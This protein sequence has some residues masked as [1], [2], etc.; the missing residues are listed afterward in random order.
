MRVIL[1]RHGETELNARGAYRGRLDVGLSRRGRAES[2]AAG[3]ALRAAPLAAVYA[4][5]LRRA[6]QTAG[7]IAARHRALAVEAAPEFIDMDFGE[8]QGK[9]VAEVEGLWPEVF[10]A[11]VERPAEARIPGGETLAAVRDRAL[12]GLRRLAAAHGDAAVVLVSHGVVNKVTLCAVLGLPVAGFWSVKQDTGA[13]SIFEFSERGSKLFLMNDV[14]HR[15]SLG[16]VVTEMG[17]SRTPVG[18]STDDERGH[19]QWPS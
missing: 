2:R 13:I 9:T 18:A 10:R 19:G 8:W 6:V 1:V 14:C 11:W 7:E 12:T 3:R 5:P 17:G 16:E 4:S 15:A